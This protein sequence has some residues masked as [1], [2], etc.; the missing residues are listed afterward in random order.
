MTMTVLLVHGMVLLSGSRIERGRDVVAFRPGADLQ[1]PALFLG[2]GTTFHRGTA[3]G[4]EV[5]PCA[6][7]LL[8]AMQHPA[9]IDVDHRRP[10][11]H[12]QV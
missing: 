8:D 10:S 12:V 6:D 3:Q 11:V 9:Q 7:R 5:R 4:D 1:T 2:W